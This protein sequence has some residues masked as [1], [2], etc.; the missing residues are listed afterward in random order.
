[1]EG[2]I[3]KKVG[4]VDTTFAR[5]DMAAAAMDELKQLCA[6][7]FERRTVPGIKDLPVEAKKLLDE[8]CDIVMAFGMP[9]KAPIDKQCAHEASLGLILA[10]LLTNKHVIEVFVHEDERE[11]EKELA[12]LAERRAREHAKN[13]FKLLFKPEELIKMAGTGQRE[14]GPDAGP[15]RR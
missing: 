1:M 9:G 6:V 2:V 13:V 7:K 3:L 10:Q 12:E 5:Y 4:I 8:G 11:D 15:L 14:G